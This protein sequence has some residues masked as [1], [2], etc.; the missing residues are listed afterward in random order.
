MKIHLI[1]PSIVITSRETNTYNRMFS[2]TTRKLV[3]RLSN[4]FRLQENY[5]RVPTQSLYEFVLM[6]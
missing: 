6:P 3:I 2:C 5:F 4:C 1:T